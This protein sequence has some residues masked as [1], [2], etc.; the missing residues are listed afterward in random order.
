[1]QRDGELHLGHVDYALAVLWYTSSKAQI[2]DLAHAYAQ[3]PCTLIAAA[4]ADLP[5]HL[6]CFL[7]QSVQLIAA[8]GQP[9]IS[10]PLVSSVH[11]LQSMVLLLSSDEYVRGHSIDWAWAET[12]VQ[13]LLKCAVAA[14][15][16][17]ALPGSSTAAAAAA[18]VLSKAAGG[19]GS[20]SS[21]DSDTE[22]RH[23]AGVIHVSLLLIDSAVEVSAVEV[24]APCKPGETY[25]ADPAG[26]FLASPAVAELLASRCLLMHKQHVQHQKEQQ[27]QGQA[28]IRQLGKRM[29]GDLL[30]LADPRD[31]L[32]PLLPSREFL[33]ADVPVPAAGDASFGVDDVTCRLQAL[34]VSINNATGGT[35]RNHAG[36][37]AA[38][39]QLSVQLLRMCA[40]YWQQT[41]HS[42]SEQ[43]QMLLSMGATDVA[44]DRMAELSRLELQL[45]PAQ[46]LFRNCMQLLHAQLSTLWG[47]GLWQPPLQLLQQGGGEVLL[48]GLTLAVHCGSLHRQLGIL[49]VFSA[50]D[51]VSAVYYVGGAQGCNFA[52]ESCMW[53]MPAIVMCPSLII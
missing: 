13:Q 49:D 10:R 22:Q 42:L 48:Q 50:P 21:R 16:M 45:A 12:V 9:V 32:L 40:A 11:L 31:R 4:A 1:L 14:G 37:S 36:L 7:W 15:V 53:I 47:S 46:Q 27:Q 20:S 33:A 44:P 35:L 30:L 2:T 28:L 19:N 52:W 3:L 34:E 51:L 6:P 38:A 29:R 43:Q 25:S 23:I 8:S 5:Q 17:K 41:Y 26:A 24:A 39:L 18:A